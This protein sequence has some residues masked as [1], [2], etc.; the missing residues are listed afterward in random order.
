MLGGPDSF[1][2][3]RYDRTPVG[4]LLPVYLIRPAAEREDESDY[5]LMLTREGF[6]QPWVRMR[7]T[8][9]EERRRL[10]EMTPFQTISRV[11]TVKPGAIVLAEVGNASGATAPALVVQQFGKGHVG[12]LLIGGLWRWGMRRENV[13]QSDL[14]RAWRQT[15]R[16]LVGDVP[17]RV[18]VSVR[19]REDSTTPAMEITARLRD[20]EY[21]PLDN[22]KVT[23]RVVRPGG[24]ELSL[25][26]EPDSREPGMYRAT[27]VTK[28]SGAYRVVAT[29]TAP[30][31]SPLGE[32]EAGWAAQPAADEFARLQPNR[33][34]LQTIATK[35]HGELIDAEKLGPF[36]ASL[37]T[38]AVPITEPWTSPLWHQP[39]Y[40]LAAIAC[41]LA[42]WGL[43]RI[44]G[45]A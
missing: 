45:L 27:Y 13:D 24:D 5:R 18:D 28:E 2:E 6:L 22:A 40:F 21:R 25:D 26:T 17:N 44:N 42:E 1:A 32:R 8:E 34:L 39:F 10:A 31:G 36:V 33:D 3:G 11:G 30:D 19:P 15:I 41:L 20:A 38:R 9:D 23:L 16:W 4:E 7:K 43:R 37:P 14:D 12:A 35:T 29:A